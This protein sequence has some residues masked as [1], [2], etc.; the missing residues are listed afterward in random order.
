L[1]RTSAN[2]PEPVSFGSARLEASHSL[3]RLATA[4]SADFYGLSDSNVGTFGPVSRAVCNRVAAP[5]G[6]MAPSRIM[7][8]D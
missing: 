8:W 7:N 3:R 4:S 5:S 2:Q 1:V 6:M